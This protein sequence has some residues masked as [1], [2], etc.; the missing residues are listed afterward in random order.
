MIKLKERSN[1]YNINFAIIERVI[2]IIA[3]V[4]MT[5]LL[6]RKLGP[7]I[8]GLYQHYAS[9]IFVATAMTWLVS[10]ESLN[11]RLDSSGYLSKEIFESVFFARLMNGSL[12]YII[13]SVYIYIKNDVLMALVL[14]MMLPF[15][16]VEALSSYKFVIESSGRMYISA[17]IRTMSAIV[18]LLLLLL[19]YL[20]DLDVI[21]IG[22]LIF[23]EAAINCGFYYLVG[24]SFVDIR[25]LKLNLKNIFFLIKSGLVV[26]IGLVSLY[27]FQRIDRIMFSHNVNGNE[28]GNYTAAMTIIDQFNTITLIVVNILAAKLVYRQDE[29]N[30][31]ENYIKLVKFII[32]LSMVSTICVFL[33]FRIC[34]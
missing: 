34:H 32:L 31:S 24:S 8:F 22:I 3:T 30:I 21:F 2:G 18:K 23:F 33:S 12:I 7:E 6:A 14:L 10:A 4:V 11:S 17:K 16:F 9:I 26:F 27:F 19:I 1:F 28:F 25:S 5:S 13:C 15:V 29:D 20:K